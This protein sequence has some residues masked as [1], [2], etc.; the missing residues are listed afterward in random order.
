MGQVEMQPNKLPCKC[1]RAEETERF[2][3]ADLL[4]E[5]VGSKK[6]PA[7]QTMGVCTVGTG[8][9]VRVTSGYLAFIHTILLTDSSDRQMTVPQPKRL[10]SSIFHVI[11]I[12]TSLEFRTLCVQD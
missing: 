9:N 8:S 6:E 5:V 11:E 3:Y 1:V 4:S 7:D 2:F 10:L 12:L